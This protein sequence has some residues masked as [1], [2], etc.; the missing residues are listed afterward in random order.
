MDSWGF[1]IRIPYKGIVCGETIPS[2]THRK[3]AYFMIVIIFGGMLP[4]FV[5]LSLLLLTFIA[6]SVVSRL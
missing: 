6:F 4:L 1:S 2:H 5:T 3:E